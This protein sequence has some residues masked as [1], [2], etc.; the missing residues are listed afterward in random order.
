MSEI[1]MTEET[2]VST[3]SSGLWKI[4]PKSNGWYVKDDNGLEIGPLAPADG[5]IPGTAT[6]SYS[7]ADSPSF[8]ASIP[9]ADA[10]LMQAGDR[11]KLT[12][13]TAKYF[14]VTAKG[15]PSGGFTPVTIYGGTDYTLANAAITSPFWSHAKSPFGFPMSP[16]K[17]TVEATTTSACTKTTPTQNVWYGG[18]GLSAT[19]PSISIP[20]GVWRVETIYNMSG[21]ANATSI[22]CFGTLSTANNSESDVDFTAFVAVIVPSASASNSCYAPVS[23]SKLLTLAAKTTYFLNIKTSATGQTSI[24]INGDLAKAFIRAVCA[25]L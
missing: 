1:T 15:S 5:W 23:K 18:A 22:N 16:A 11:I 14:I 13:T 9:D 6:W 17:W 2:S 7:S 21:N 19:G 20:I 8:V 3:P 25:Y 12:Q 24:G 4:Y 10:A